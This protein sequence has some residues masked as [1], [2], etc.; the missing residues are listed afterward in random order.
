MSRIAAVFAKKDHK[1][2]IAYVTVGYPSMWA[3]L[4]AVPLLAECGCDIIEL[5]IPFSDPLADGTTIQK[6]S[7]DALQNGVTPKTCIETAQKLR[8]KTNV[9]IVFMSYYNPIFHYGVEKFCADSKEAGVDGLIIPDLPPEEGTELGN[10]CAKHGLDLIYLLAPT[11]TDERTKLI[12][13][14][15]SGFIYMVSVTGV[16]GARAALPQ[17][18][19]S[20]VSRVKQVTDKPLCVGFGIS[21]PQQA[22]QVAE[23][24]DGVIIG[25]R[26]IQLL[27]SGVSLDSLR[28][29]AT[30]L[31]AALD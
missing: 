28:N 18:L 6:A 31:R 19:S 13:E 23:I 14:K 2:F 17:E 12:A 1:A 15:S 30:E 11:S 16:T 7:F 26:I 27:E 25:S 29:F 4:Q 9:P 21:T 20:F 3:T 24:S 10:A 5:G 22:K 8:L